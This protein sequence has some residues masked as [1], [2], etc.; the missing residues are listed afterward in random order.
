[1]LA[2]TCVDQSVGCFPKSKRSLVRFPFGIHAWVT[3]SVLSQGTYKRHLIDVLSYIDV[4]LPLF[5]PPLSKN[6]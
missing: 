4:S 6:K 1:M 3:G 2:L 5:L